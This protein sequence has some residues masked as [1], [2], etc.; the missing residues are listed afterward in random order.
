MRVELFILLIGYFA[1]CQYLIEKRPF[2][3]KILSWL[4]QIN[5]IQL[6]L[7]SVVVMFISVVV[8]IWI[9][10]LLIVG[11]MLIMF[12]ASYLVFRY[13]KILDRS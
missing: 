13:K 3:P 8:G 2:Q 7:V 12:L 5:Y 4:D 6:M 9:R 10:P 1:I 11:I